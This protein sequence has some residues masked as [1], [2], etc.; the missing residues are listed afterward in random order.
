MLR[1]K[2]IVK[3]G[4]V[5]LLGLC[6]FQSFARPGAELRMGSP[7]YAGTGCSPGSVGIALAPDG[8]SLSLLFDDYQVRADR[9]QRVAERF[10][11]MTIPFDVPAG[12]SMTII[13][14]DYRGF[15]SLPAGGASE[16]KTQY[17]FNGKP[18]GRPHRKF[19]VIGPLQQD[20]LDSNVENIRSR[21]K[22]D[23]DAKD[24]LRINTL[25]RVASNSNGDEAFSQLDSADVQGAPLGKKR[26]FRYHIHLIPC[27]RGNGFGRVR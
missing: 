18:T 4:L 25:L 23:A 17:E 7:T 10:C 26:H 19:K 8:K 20:F 27:P 6:S 16:L 14:V 12:Y 1:K 21:C 11:D 3:V 24:E 5:G 15:N 13:R 2:T 22:S 9:T